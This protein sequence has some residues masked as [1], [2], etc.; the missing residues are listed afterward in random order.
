[1]FTGLHFQSLDDFIY[2]KYCIVRP[3]RMLKF[4]NI[5]IESNVQNIMN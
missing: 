5:K 3:H 2:G 4:I 1:M